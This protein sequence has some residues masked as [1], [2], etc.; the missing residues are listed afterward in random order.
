M[1]VAVDGTLIKPDGSKETFRPGIDANKRSAAY[2]FYL[3]KIVWPWLEDYIRPY[4][5]LDRHRYLRGML[6]YYGVAAER[7]RNGGNMAGKGKISNFGG[8]K[9]APFAKG[10][11]RRKS[12]S[13]SSSAKK[14]GK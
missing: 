3:A 2:N 13:K 4:R 7:P 1:G 14:S 9:A 10:G 12:S 5:I 11:G 8:K 6:T